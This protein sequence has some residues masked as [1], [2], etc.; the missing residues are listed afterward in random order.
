MRSCF[1]FDSLLELQAG[2]RDRAIGL[3]GDK[4]PLLRM[5]K[6]APLFELKPEQVG[7][8][9]FRMETLR[10]DLFDLARTAP[11]QRSVRVVAG[12]KLTGQT[13]GGIRSPVADGGG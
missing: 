3:H 1:V 12:S 10:C 9:N 8:Y 7:D 11:F 2:V 6:D 4:S 5:K 13:A